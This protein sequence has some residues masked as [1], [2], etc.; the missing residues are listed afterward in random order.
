MNFILEGIKKGIILLFGL[1]SEVLVILRLSLWVSMLATLIAVLIG[2]PLGSIIAIK[3]FPFKKIIIALINTGMGLPPVVVGLFVV[4][5][6]SRSG[7]FGFLQW[8]YTPI[9]MVLAQVIIATPIITGL[10]LAA[11]QSVDPR[12]Y[13][14]ILSL[15]ATTTQS[16][17]VLLKEIRLSILAAVIAGFGSVISEVGAVMMVGGNIKGQTR[18]LTTATVLETH[19]GNF[20]IAIALGLIL[21]TMSFI[22]NLALTFIQQSREKQK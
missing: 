10:S 16:I 2:V 19:M 17:W 8:L 15:G 18:V 13:Q 14:Q 7:P 20:E 22:V 3:K 6:L 21:I 1:N 11:V 5:F 9:G 4:L 12:F